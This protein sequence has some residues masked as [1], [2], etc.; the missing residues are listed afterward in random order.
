ME[1]RCGINRLEGGYSYVFLDTF[2]VFERVSADFERMVKNYKSLNPKCAYSGNLC[3][4]VVVL[5]YLLLKSADFKKLSSK[6]VLISNDV[7][8]K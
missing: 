4:T 1:A 2:C 3:I 7:H 8:S 5:M 6:S